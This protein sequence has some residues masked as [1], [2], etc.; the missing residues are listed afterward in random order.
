MDQPHLAAAATRER[1]MKVLLADDEPVSLARIEAALACVPEARLCGIARNGREALELIRGLNP[2]VAV[3]DIQMPVRDAF[4]VLESLE[5]GDNLPEIIFAT[6]YNAYATRAFDLNAVDYLLKPISFDRFRMALRRA[7]ARLDARENDQR[8]AEVQALLACH[9]EQQAAGARVFERGF[10]VRGREGMVRVDANMVER[11][12]AEGD[13]VRLHTKN[14]RYLISDT[15]ARLQGVLDPQQ[16][17]R[18]HRSTIVNLACVTEVRRRAP[19]GLLLILA[20]GVKLPVGPTYADHVSRQVQV[21]RWRS[22]G[23]ESLKV[24]DRN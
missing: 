2:D 13:Y 23:S 5:P 1:I 16:F 11:L 21:R 15:I 9:R 22:P 12:E 4:G 18:I 24:G 8:F 3:L 10:W 20:G 6:A 19:R 7:K 17:A 14:A